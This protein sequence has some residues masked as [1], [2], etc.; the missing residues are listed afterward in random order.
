MK[1][2]IFRKKKEDVIPKKERRT[3]SKS[4]TT[5]FL[6]SFFYKSKKVTLKY[7]WLCRMNHYFHFQLKSCG[8]KTNIEYVI[9]YCRDQFSYLDIVGTLILKEIDLKKLHYETEVDFNVAD[10]TS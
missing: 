3:F 9:K 4:E 8:T 1:K 2:I 6:S 5:V 10:T 7:G